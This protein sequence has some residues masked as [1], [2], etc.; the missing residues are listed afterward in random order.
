MANCKHSYNDGNSNYLYCNITNQICPLVRWCND[1]GRVIS[2][3]N[4][5]ENCIYYKNKEESM[6]QS[7]GSHK[8]RFVK[9][10][11]LY[12]EL[13]DK[14]NQIAK[15]DN[16]YD[17]EPFYVDIVQVGDNYYVKGFEP[18]VEIKVEEELKEEIEP[19]ESIGILKE[20]AEKKPKK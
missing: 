3:N 18:K 1:V 17:Y 2:I 14:L 13:N 16:P 19:E 12:V 10:K 20:R 11:L 6:L 8:V 9:R 15:I 7:N 5:R 4:Y